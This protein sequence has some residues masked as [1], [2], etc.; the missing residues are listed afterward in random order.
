MNARR[1]RSRRAPLLPVLAALVFVGLT[2]IAGRFL[3]GC[4]EAAERREPAARTSRPAAPAQPRPQPGPVVA[5]IIDD[6][7]YNQAEE[8]RP[9]LD[10][11]ASFTLAVLPGLPRTARFAREA[12][13][14]REVILHLPMEPV[15]YPDT[16]PGQPAVMRGMGEGEI[17]KILETA[18][19]S[20]PDVRGLNNHMGS[21]ATADPATMRALMRVLH[22]RGLFFV[23][24]VTTDRSAAAAT[25]AAE[26]VPCLR[27]RIF[28]DH[29]E[30]QPEVIRRRLAALISLAR[31][32]GT[33]VGIG[34]PRAA[35]AEVLAQE[36]PRYQAAGVRFLTVSELLALQS[37]AN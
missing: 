9:L 25:A 2:A 27:N 13:R 35:T 22:A 16:D 7:G 5:I 24:S 6:W 37:P 20:L 28:L 34:H 19:A 10:L 18:L 31:A 30:P 15:G 29:D 33:A 23:D 21:A 36:I 8:A 11:P 4:E 3:G 14:R 1:Q 17:A 26:G 12:S 32:G